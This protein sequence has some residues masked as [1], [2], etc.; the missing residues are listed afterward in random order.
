MT[1]DPRE[2][3]GPV[4]SASVEALVAELVAEALAELPRSEE[5]PEYLDVRAAARYLGCPSEEPVRKLIARRELPVS[6][7][8]KGHRIYIARAEL[9]ALM[10][11][12]RS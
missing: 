2:L 3:L 10:R 5:W 6:Q 7:E 8:A 1:I 4:L 9:D 11:S 12:W